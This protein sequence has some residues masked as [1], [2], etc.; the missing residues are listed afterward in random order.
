[1]ACDTNCNCSNCASSF[2]FL[3][4]P[5]G[6]KGL[7]GADSTVPGPPADPGDP[8]VSSYTYIAYATDAAGTG[9]VLTVPAANSTYI[10]FLNTS[11]AITPVVGDFTGLFIK[12]V[13]DAPISAFPIG[14]WLYYRGDN[15]AIG[16]GTPVSL[17]GLNDNLS[18]SKGINDLLGFALCDGASYSGFE[19]PDYV[20]KFILSTAEEGGGTGI[21]A[22]G[23]IHAQTL[24]ANNIPLHTHPGSL[25]G[26]SATSAGGQSL[27]IRTAATAI[28]PGIIPI[29]Y[30]N[31]PS[32]ESSGYVQDVDAH[33][34]PVVGTVTV[35][36]NV[37]T[38]DTFD[39]R[40]AF[41]RAAAIIRLPDGV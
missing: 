12:F 31:T 28:T 24:D 15:R 34:H 13:A 18:G 21:G 3:V 17:G 11:T 41:V 9:F 27:G 20:N 38:V 33:T 37:S 4:G 16:T 25:S 22:F 1:M 5:K 26:A 36:N 30:L 35:S 23:G 40:P 6:D 8:G 19:T 10:A 29:T 32:P 14:S 2:L 39:N 7:T